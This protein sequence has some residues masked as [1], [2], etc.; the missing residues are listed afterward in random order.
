MNLLNIPSIPQNRIPSPGIYILPLR[1]HKGRVVEVT[2]DIP[3][4]GYPLHPLLNHLVSTK[5][6]QYLNLINQY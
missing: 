3:E 6:P 2:P 1:Y 4:E 5:Y